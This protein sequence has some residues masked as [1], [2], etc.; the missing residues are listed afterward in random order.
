MRFAVKTAP[1]KTTW[2]D[3]LAVWRAADEIDLFE[4]AWSFDHFE[5]IYGDRS[6]PCLEGWTTLA[7]LAQATSRIRVGVHGHRHAL[8]APRGAGQHGGVGRHRVGRPPRAGAG[9]R[10][11]REGGQRLRHRPA[12]G[13]PA[14]GPLRR[15]A[16]TSSSVCSPSPASA[17][18]ASTSRSTAA[19]ASRRRCRR[20]TRRSASAAAARSARCGPSP[21]WPSTGTTSAGRSTSSSACAACSTP[22]APTSGAT[23]ARS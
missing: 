11:E 5:P 22:T 9:R 15:G 13:A 16:A 23:R 20:R 10:L 3:M 18:R 17:T 6:Q 7:A 1:E 12:A 4:S 14:H 21:A 8:P 19:T 2:Q